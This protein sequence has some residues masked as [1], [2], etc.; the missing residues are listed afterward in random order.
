M[1][2]DIGNPYRSSEIELRF[3]VWIWNVK[4]AC[5]LVD[6]RSII[7]L[8]LLPYILQSEV[9]KPR[10]KLRPQAWKLRLKLRLKLRPEANITRLRLEFRVWLLPAAMGPYIGLARPWLLHT[11]ALHTILLNSILLLPS[12]RTPPSIHLLHPYSRTP[13]P[14]QNPKVKK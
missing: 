13:A 14:Y 7:V 12:T 2:V 5:L 6:S 11:I 1:Y 4:Y 9:F 3:K 10:L 8:I